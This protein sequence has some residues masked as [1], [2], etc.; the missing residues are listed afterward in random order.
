M[1]ATAKATPLD[2]RGLMVDP[3]RLVERHEFYFDLLAKLPRWGF[4]T[5]WWHFVDDEGFVLKLRS[6]PELATPYAF[7]KAET[8]RLLAAASD[9]GI[10]VVPE[11][12]TLGHRRY[13]T[14]LPQ[15]AHL[16]DGD[17]CDFNAVCPSHRDTLPLLAEIIREVA[18]LFD[19][20]YFHA[21]LDEVNLSG[22]RRCERR[23]RGRPRWY[24]FGRHVRAIHEIV[25]A[26]GKRMIM[27]ADHVEEAPALLKVL[28][29]DIVLAHWQYGQLDVEA[30]ERSLDAGF[31]VIC[32]P[33]MLSHTTVI[34]PNRQAAENTE[35]MIAAARRLT[36]RGVL[37]AVN[38]WWESWRILRDAALPMAAYSGHLLTGGR[39]ERTAFFRC[40]LRDQFGLQSTPA[41]EAMWQLH[42]LAPVLEELLALLCDNPA[43][44]LGAITLAGK[45]GFESRAAT[46]CSAVETLAA[47]AGKVRRNA[48]GFNASVL[49]GK[50]AGGCLQNG[51][52]L[53][54]AY[55]CY[56]QAAQ[57]RN[58]LREDELVA[59]HLDE[60]AEVFTA[61]GRRL[62]VLC[63]EVS[64]EWDRTRHRGDA[65]KASGSVTAPCQ[66]DM[67]L[68][69]MVRCREF[70]RRLAGNFKRSIAAYRRGGPFPT[71]V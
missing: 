35:Q 18:E 13:I 36:R 5:L 39:P 61:M 37:G 69:R 41:A 62:D 24:L 25:T 70:L 38:T 28:P 27:W 48:D 29:K 42:E 43:A 63:R 32:A 19:S 6:H 47:A 71:G 9:V 22:C 30:I 4:N 14:R 56:R 60:A 65:K 1:A 17:P 55:N 45:S 50:V 34:Q 58:R 21:G 64:A 46:V 40:F 7:T 66:R 67:L 59:R 44:M 3:A 26:C 51:L 20:E 53:L 54:R 8:T 68:G 23:A 49:A 31:E 2:I 33:A 16:A 10:E 57:Q 11:V 15:Y 12:E 52:D